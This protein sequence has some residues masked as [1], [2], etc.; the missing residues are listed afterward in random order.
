MSSRS[1]TFVSF[2]AGAATIAAA[3]AFFKSTSGKKIQHR[4]LSKLKTA[5]DGANQKAD[6]GIDWLNDLSNSAIHNA[7]KLSSKVK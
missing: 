6:Q 4:M 5:R 1:K 2:I 7:K 3:S